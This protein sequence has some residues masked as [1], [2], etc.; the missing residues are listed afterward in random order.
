[1]IESPANSETSQPTAQSS[2]QSE[3]SRLEKL[4]ELLDDEGESPSNGEARESDENAEPKGK[5]KGKPKALA[6]LAER[7]EL[8]PADLYAVEIPFDDGTSRSIGK[9][10]DTAAKESDLQV[11]EL[12]FEEKVSTTEAEWTR[13]Q[14]ELQTLMGSIDPK[15]IKPETREKVKAHFAAQAT[16]ERAL[17]LQHI[18]QWSNETVRNAELAGMVELLKD[19]GIG[20]AFLSAAPNHKLFRFVRDAFLRKQRIE[21]A[22]AKVTE[23]KKPSTTGRSSAGNG[24][25]TREVPKPKGKSNL[26]SRVLGVLE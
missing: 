7:L 26:R 12:A 17:T 3:P 18:P 9:L 21:A 6:E 1:M 10:K 15:A 20:E 13:A 4:R 2:A 14:H 5:P 23:I 11:R 22:L 16:K 24:S 25:P 8:T 19:Y